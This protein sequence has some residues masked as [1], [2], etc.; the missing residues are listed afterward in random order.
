MQ[1][2]LK[3]FLGDNALVYI[4][5]GVPPL[6]FILLYALV[7]LYMEM[8]VSAHIQDRVAYMRTGWH[9]VLQPFAD[10]L[11]LIQKEDI[12]PA[13][14]D[15]L[16]FTLAPYLVFTGTYAG[17]AAIPFS[18]GYIGSNINLGVFY[19]VAAS[20]IVV[21]GLLMSGWASNNKWS[22]LGAMRSAAQIVS[23]EIPSALAILVAV[24]ITGS[25]NLNDV[26]KFQEGGL[27]NWVVFGGPLPLLQ[28]LA[29]IP[30]TATA[31]FILLTAG[32]AEANRTPF[33]LPEAESEL[34]QGFNTE[35]SGMKFA[36]FYVAEYANMFLV[37][38]VAVCLFLGGWQSPFGSALSGPIWGVFWIVIKGMAFVFFQIWLR[39]TLPRLRVD[40]LMYVSWK[41]MTPM[42]FVCVF[43]VGLILVL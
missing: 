6:I 39:W 13:Q 7:T 9:G 43:A 21:A 36:I 20:S 35:Y 4:I 40:Q 34:V 16:L 11:K 42:L 32:I 28:K 8:K 19:I 24:M 22:L 25:L 26:S 3:S 23:Y 1:E 29:I 2:L 37:S 30:F 5:M 31:F 27:F 15:K 18:E 38:A 33:D 12:I 41:V 14:A 10:I 17:F